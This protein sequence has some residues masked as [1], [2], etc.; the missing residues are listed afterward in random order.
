MLL[1]TAGIIELDGKIL[2]AKRREGK[3]LEP[4]WEFPGGKMEEGE[5]PEECLQRELMEELSFHTEIGEYFC[6]SE[7]DCG[8][9]HITILAYKVKYLSGELKIVDH[10]DVKWVTLEE[11]QNFEF[12]RADKLIVEKLTNKTQ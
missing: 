12:V 10:D 7:F 3:C 4:L 1:V 9:K 5:T 2:I 6:T 11:L 8:E